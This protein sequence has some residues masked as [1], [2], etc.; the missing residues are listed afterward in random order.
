MGA[1]DREGTWELGEFPGCY[2]LNVNV[3]L[4]AHCLI[5][6]PHLVALSGDSVRLLGGR[7]LLEVVGHYGEG[8]FEESLCFKSRLCSLGDVNCHLTEAFLLLHL[9]CCDG[10]NPC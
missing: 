4:L 1:S 6:G 7:V 8:G 9:F 10:V 5:F 3:P 2:G